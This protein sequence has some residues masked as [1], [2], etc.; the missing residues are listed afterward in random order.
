MR[1]G[2]LE[3]FERRLA[4]E[5]AEAKRSDRRDVRQV[6]TRMAE[7]YRARIGQLRGGSVVPTHQLEVG[8]IQAIMHQG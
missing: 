5:L 8:A 1:E 4:Q 7:L 3:Y 6:H 2:D